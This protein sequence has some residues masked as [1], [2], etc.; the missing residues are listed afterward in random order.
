LQF[1]ASPGKKVIPPKITQH[2]HSKRA[3]GV[4]QVIEHLPHKSEA[5]SS[6]PSNAKKE[7]YLSIVINFTIGFQI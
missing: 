3:G 1:E 5:L 6:K 2:T 7:R 4:T